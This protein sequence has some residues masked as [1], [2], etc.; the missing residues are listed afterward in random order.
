MTP[1]PGAHAARRKGF[2]SMGT[3]GK[4]APQPTVNTL[5]AAAL[6]KCAERGYADANERKAF[7]AGYAR[8][9]VGVDNT[10]DN[11][12][13]EMRDWPNAFGAGYWEGSAD[14]QSDPS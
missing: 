4:L 13:Q 5:H 9:Y 11:E 12:P 10:G 6:R 1:G 2:Y 14:V 3:F 8:G 7:L